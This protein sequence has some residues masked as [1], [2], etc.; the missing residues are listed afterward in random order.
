MCKYYFFLFLGSIPY[1]YHIFILIF[2]FSS[3]NL[4]DFLG[5]NYLNNLTQTNNNEL[6]DKEINE[7]KNELNK[8]KK[9]V[10]QQKITIE[11]LKNKLNNKNDGDNII[12]SLKNTIRQ[13]DQELIKLRTELQN[14]NNNSTNN[15]LILDRNQIMAVNFISM[16]QKV[17]FCVPCIDTDIFAEIEEKLYKQF[18]EYRETNNYFL[19]QGKQV[20]RFKTIAQNNIGNGLPV[21]LVVPHN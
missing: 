3:T 20:L 21:T 2:Q 6:K 12:Q 15:K 17:H 5:N 19:S 18:P 16:D 4:K 10:E 9:I 11:D 7:L 14:K 13:K 1:F 8:Y